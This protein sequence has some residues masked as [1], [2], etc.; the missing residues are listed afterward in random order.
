[1]IDPIDNG[2]LIDVAAKYCG[3]ALFCRR[4]DDQG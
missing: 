3:G 1:M 2:E 4:P